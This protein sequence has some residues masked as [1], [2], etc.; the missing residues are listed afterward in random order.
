MFPNNSGFPRSIPINFQLNG[1]RFRL[2]CRWCLYCSK[3]LPTQS[4]TAPLCHRFT[5]K[6]GCF[7]IIW[8][9]VWNIFYFHPY[10]GLIP[11]LTNI[12][13]RGWNHQ[14]VMVTQLC[15]WNVVIYY[16]CVRRPQHFR[17]LNFRT[18]SWYPVLRKRY[19]MILCEGVVEWRPEVMA[20]PTTPIKTTPNR[21]KGFARTYEGKPIVTKS[22]LRPYFLGSR[23]GG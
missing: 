19:A 16:W 20:L 1:V 10:L 23:F 2:N 15:V 9:V 7:K 14:L 21:N 8:L 4:W 5:E 13:Q 12:F 22:L 11:I 3:N 17:L 6:S 18:Y